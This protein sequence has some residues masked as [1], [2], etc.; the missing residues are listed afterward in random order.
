[1]Q[2][3][4]FIIA[5]CACFMCA[6][7]ITI[8]GGKNNPDVCK[9]YGRLESK[10]DILTAKLDRS[11]DMLK[12]KNEQVTDVC[13]GDGRLES[14]VDILTAKLDRSLDM[15]KKNNVQVKEIMITVR[16]KTDFTKLSLKTY[17]PL[18]NNKYDSALLSRRTDDKN[19]ALRK[20]SQQSSWH[21]KTHSWGNYVCCATEYANDGN[22]TT[23]SHT[24][25]DN[26][27]YWLVD[28]ENV[29]D[30]KRI[31]IINRFDFAG[32]RLKNADITV[33]STLKEMSLC[34]HYK[35]PAKLKEHLIFYC[36]RQMRGR[37]V[38]VT[39]KAKEYLH[40]SEVMVFAPEISE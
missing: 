17:H 4:V 18:D 37:Y 34:A 22:A 6:C 2:Q 38:K 3:V 26:L 35:G 16:R 31:E 8:P 33:G 12:K 15:V 20:K 24:N 25:Y 14:K 9:E 27:P 11:L 30:I 23:Y 13:K 29:Y 19:V 32:Q 5:Y 39:I 1:M 28:L 36:N 10:V 21:L 7:Q 40:L